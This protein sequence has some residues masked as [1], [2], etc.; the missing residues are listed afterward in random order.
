MIGVK[1]I[2]R[3]PGEEQGETFKG[4]DH[5]CKKWDFGKLKVEGGNARKRKRIKKGGMQ[6]KFGFFLGFGGNI[7]LFVNPR[8]CGW[9][10]PEKKRK[11]TWNG[12][13]IYW[14]QVYTAPRWGTKAWGGGN[15]LKR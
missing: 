13:K 11:K 7:C 2:F 10:V 3:A 6:T 12:G 4:K 5:V 14:E 9:G 1:Q 8:V 15:N